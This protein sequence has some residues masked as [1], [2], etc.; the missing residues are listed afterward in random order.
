MATCFQDTPTKPDYE[1]VPSAVFCQPPVGTVGLTEE[2]VV[3]KV[4]KATYLPPQDPPR[5]S[6]LQ[7]SNDRRRN[8][9]VLPK[10]SPQGAGGLLGCSHP[11]SRRER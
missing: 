10:V 7:Q 4:Q 3:E 5:G 11:N 9:R 2:Q 6:D 1:Y 8:L